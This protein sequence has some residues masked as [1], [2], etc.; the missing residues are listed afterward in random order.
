MFS[1]MEICMPRL[2]II[3]I[4]FVALIL[5]QGVINMSK[6]IDE[7][8]I[9]IV[10]TDT[11]KPYDKNP[12]EHSERQISKLANAIKKR[13]FINPITVDKNNVIIAGHGRYEAAKLLKLT[14]IPVIIITHLSEA[15]IRIQ[16]I[17]D[18]QLG[19]TSS[20]NK[21]LNSEVV[22]LSVLSEIEIEDTGFETPEL[23]ILLG[24]GAVK[25]DNDPDDDIP[26]PDNSSAVTKPGDIWQLRD[27]RIICG[28]AKKMATYQGL[29][30]SAKADI[31]VTD[32]P[33]NV[34]IQG[35]VCGNGKNKHR[36]F[37]EASGELSDK[38]F[39]NFLEAYMRQVAKF[40][41]DGSIHYHFMDW[42]HSAHILAAGNRVYSELNNICVWAKTNGGMGSFYRSQHELV[43]VYKNGTKPHVNN[44]QLGKFGNYRTNLWQYAGVNS[45]AGRKENGEDLLSLHPT[46]KPV[47]MLADAIKDCT[48]R[49]D[50]VLDPFA[51][52]GSTLIAAERI[53]RVAYCI[54][55]DAKYCDIIV[56]RW[57]RMT[58][59]EAYNPDS[60]V[61]FNEL[62][63]L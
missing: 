46:V 49:G 22:D 23:D 28:D 13:G 21:H 8:K 30:G 61:T 59:L 3:K 41:R 29:M 26:E 7:L 60:L 34:K 63:D 9:S 2:L 4:I 48:K 20:W 12:R 5:M 45:F 6:N 40:S 38:E 51:G 50:I 1:Q 33:Y 11:V 24:Y 54:E 62:L 18:N 27:H 19:L 14:K 43:F 15:E 16:R 37:A 53:G 44:I 58:G 31:V 39:E 47:A 55:L 52:S 57:Q 17:A 35:H 10:P 32:P 25:E 42:R 36:E 56:Q